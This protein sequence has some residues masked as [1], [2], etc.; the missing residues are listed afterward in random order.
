MGKKI[1]WDGGMYK[2]SRLEQ[3]FWLI[4]KRLFRWDNLPSLA[5]LRFVQKSYL[6]LLLIPLADQFFSPLFTLPTGA[7]LELNLGWIYIVP[8]NLKVSFELAMPFSWSLIYF[9]V[10]FL[11][12]GSIL[13]EI[14]LPRIIG[15][16]PET[17]TTKQLV[18][19]N[20]RE[21]ANG[22][23]F[24]RRAN[25]FIY[26]FAVRYTTNLDILVAPPDSDIENAAKAGEE[27]IP[28]Q[29]GDSKTRVNQYSVY[30]HAEH[31]QLKQDELDDAIETII[32]FQNETRLVVRWLC[33]SFFLL[34][35]CIFLILVWQG[36]F[37]M[38]I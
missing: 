19:Q 8:E 24:P 26:D 13:Y 22:I 29:T 21:V 20:W 37:R 4:D 25:H 30:Y 9:L 36:F 2:K 3:L 32:W 6:F 11:G 34:S 35:I 7:R 18:M 12:A 31:M 17:K 1:N 23:M 16:S 10:F 5:K 15:R 33:G 27:L 14:Y 28:L 38:V